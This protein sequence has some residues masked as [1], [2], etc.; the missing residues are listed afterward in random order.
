MQMAFCVR[1]NL[2]HIV[3]HNTHT[4]TWPA[5]G[6]T[7]FCDEIL[8]NLASIILRQFKSPCVMQNRFNK[9]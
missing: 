3:R 7:I 5:I 6:T 8:N 1:I 2:V 4:N 9:L